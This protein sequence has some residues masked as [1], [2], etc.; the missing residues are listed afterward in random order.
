VECHWNAGSVKFTRSCM[1]VHPAAVIG[2]V[3]VRWRG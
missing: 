1:E 2:R 3:V